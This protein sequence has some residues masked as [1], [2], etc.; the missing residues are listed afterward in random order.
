MAEYNLFITNTTRTKVPVLPFAT[1]KEAVLGKEY[2]L[3][4]VFVGEAK[5]KELNLAYRDKD[6]PTDILSFTLS[7]TSGEI[8]IC[9]SQAEKKSTEFDRD[10]NNFLQFLFIHGMF[11]LKGMEH[12]STMEKAEKK[13]REKFDL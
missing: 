8:F 6:M 11:H 12:G 4:L 2:E 10:S 1:L 9:P 13:I 5:I 7:D 3:S